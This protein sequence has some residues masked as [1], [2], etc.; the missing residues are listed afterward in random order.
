M[1]PEEPKILD[2][3]Y[4]RVQWALW[5]QKWS[6]SRLTKAMNKLE[7]VEAE[8]DGLGQITM[9]GRGTVRRWLAGEVDKAQLRKILQAAQALGVNERWLIF[10]DGAPYVRTHARLPQELERTLLKHPVASRVT[11]DAVVA[12]YERHPGIELSA[13]QWL[14][15]RMAFEEADH[16]ALAVLERSQSADDVKKVATLKERLGRVRGSAVPPV[17]TQSE[18]VEPKGLAKRRP[19]KS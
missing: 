6:M 1:H 9:S 10:R 8:K 3:W 12:F 14:A 18:S 19:R 7:S 17:D 5:D 13:E 16:D 4:Q 11:T 15:I 2:E